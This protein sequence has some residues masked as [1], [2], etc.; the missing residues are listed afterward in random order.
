MKILEI[1]EENCKQ[2]IER[3]QTCTGCKKHKWCELYG[4]FIAWI[5]A[6]SKR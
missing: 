3:N 5:K 4:S 1:A 2:A 6:N